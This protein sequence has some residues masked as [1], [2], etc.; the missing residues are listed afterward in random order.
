VKDLHMISD[1]SSFDEEDDRIV[2]EHIKKTS[3]FFYPTF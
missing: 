1:S 3:Q 2:L